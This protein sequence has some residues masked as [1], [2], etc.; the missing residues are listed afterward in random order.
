MSTWPGQT[1]AASRLHQMIVEQ[2]QDALIVADAEGT[3]RVWNR[4]AE[5]LF[6][7]AAAEAI[8]SGLDLLVPPRFR[9]AH[10]HGFRQAI[11]TGHLRTEGR[12]LTTRSNHKNGCRLY[13]D[14][15]FS[16]LK[17]PRGQVVGVVA[18]A[19]DATARHLEEVAHRLQAS[20]A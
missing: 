11:A 12:V 20:V 4:G 2:M 14:F 6:G 10:D 18:V 9:Q 16:L 1:L 15:S 7:F 19:R 8:G 3:I 17:D 13:V 5:V